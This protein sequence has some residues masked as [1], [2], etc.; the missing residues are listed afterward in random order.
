MEAA[1]NEKEKIFLEVEKKF[2]EIQELVK[3]HLLQIF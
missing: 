3:L 2:M 1:A